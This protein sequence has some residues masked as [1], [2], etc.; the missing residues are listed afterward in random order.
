M[1]NEGRERAEEISSLGAAGCNSI[2]L[3]K[4]SFFPTFYLP[5]S[6]RIILK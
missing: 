1:E 5:C 3:I 2:Q 6:E 4:K